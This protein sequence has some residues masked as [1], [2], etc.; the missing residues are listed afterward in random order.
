MGGRT[1]PYISLAKS[2][3]R[4][5]IALESAME[6]A[7]VNGAELASGAAVH[8]HTVQRLRRGR[9]TSMPTS[10]AKRIEDALRVARGGLFLHPGQSEEVAA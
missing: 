8:R 10:A 7:D 9:Q 1:M 4:S 5:C 3:L 2:Q 6:Q